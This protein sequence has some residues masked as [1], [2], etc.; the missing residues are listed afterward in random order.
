M[1]KRDIISDKNTLKIYTKDALIERVLLL[2]E[3]IIDLKD[4]NKELLNKIEKNAMFFSEQNKIQNLEP[5]IKE[6]YPILIKII[7]LFEGNNNYKRARKGYGFQK[8]PSKKH[9][10][11]Y[12]V[13]YYDNG[14]MIPTSWNTQTNVLDEAKEFAEKKRTQLLSEYYKK[15]SIKESNIN[16]YKNM[17]MI[18]KEFYSKDSIFLNHYKKLNITFNDDT[19]I[20]N[21]N[22]INKTFIPFLKKNNI[23]TFSDITAHIIGNF[24]LFLI[25]KNK[26]PNCISRYIKA[27]EYIFSNLA[28][29]GIIETN[30]FERIPKIRK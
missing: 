7:Q 1:E 30:V 20:Y 26:T 19:R 8:K 27:I 15:Q 11:L 29:M 2:Q 18:L 28:M 3:Y 22:I 24:Q 23:K 14:K 10:F 6:I 16:D 17:F 13:R 9:G 21:N 12:Y 4:N 5:L 25:E